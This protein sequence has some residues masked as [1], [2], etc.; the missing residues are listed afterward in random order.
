MM[1]RKKL[2]ISETIEDIVLK[3]RLR[4][5]GDVVRNTS[6]LNASYN[7]DFKKETK[8]AKR[9]SD[10]IREQCGEPLLNI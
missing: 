2:N 10:G 5:F 4:W 8:R 1:I 6:T 3:R 9:W 7:L